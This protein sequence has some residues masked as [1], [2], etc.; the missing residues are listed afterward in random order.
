MRSHSTHEQ[1]KTKLVHDVFGDDD[2]SSN[3]HPVSMDKL[4]MLIWSFREDHELIDFVANFLAKYSSDNY[5]FDGIEFYLPQL[6]HMMIHLRDVEWPDVTLERFAL[7][8]AQKSLHFA[9]QMH[10]ILTGAMQDYQP[11]NSDGLPNERFNA[12]FYRRCVKLRRNLEFAVVFG[13]NHG[14]P[15]YNEM[16]RMLASGEISREEFDVME[17]G[18]YRLNAHRILEGEATYPVSQTIK[19]SKDQAS[20]MDQVLQKIESE[21]CGWL[22]Y[23]R[24]WRKK[25]YKRKGWKHRFF[26]IE[27]GMLYCYDD[28]PRSAQESKVAS[29]MPR[30]RRAMPLEGAKVVLCPIGVYKDENGEHRRNRHLHCFEVIN[31]LYKFKLRAKTEAEALAWVKVLDD[32]SK[33]SSLFSNNTPN[34]S[35][36]SSLNSEQRARYE[37]FKQQ[38]TFVDD[39]CD[40]AEKLRFEEREQRKTLLSDTMDAVTVPDCAYIPM[41]KST[42]TFASVQSLVGNES[43]VFSTNERCPVLMY[44]YNIRNKDNLGITEF[45]HSKYGIKLEAIVESTQD[46]EEDDEQLEEKVDETSTSA[47]QIVNN[48]SDEHPTIET[49]ADNEDGINNVSIVINEPKPSFHKKISSIFRR[50]VGERDNKVSRGF[51]NTNRMIRKLVKDMHLHD[52]PKVIKETLKKGASPRKLTALDK[53]DTLFESVKIVESRSMDSISTNG[54]GTSAME[55]YGIDEA[56]LQNAKVIVCGGETWRERKLRLLSSFQD[57]TEVSLYGD[58]SSVI[59]KSHDD[60]RQEVFVMQMIHYYQSVFVSANLPI[61]LRPYRILSCSKSTGL[62]ETLTD[63]TSIDGLKKS[64]GYPKEGGLRAYFEQVYGAP[65]GKNFKAAQRN[66]MLSLAGYSL[67][68]YLLGLK[69]RHNGNIMIDIHGHLIFIDFGF[70]MGMAPGHEWSLER[71]AF[72][73]TK[74]YVDVM[75]GID[76]ECFKE[77][78]DLFVNG[79]KAARNNSQMALGLVE[80]MMYKSNYPCFSGPRYGGTK[81]LKRF[82]NRLMLNVQEKDIRKKAEKLVMN[83]YNHCGTNLYDKFQLSSNG[84]EP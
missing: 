12:V 51:D 59:A 54:S 72:K 16:Q 62:I 6:A 83:A 8:V 29:D 23:K 39:L 55:D 48:F 37:F 74:E 71:A 31:Q 32:Q 53:A 38:I 20:A 44:F 75:D 21:R 49:T 58:V 36:L 24:R 70:A 45:L 69:D 73:L 64:P 3:N 35:L 81:T 61:W 4:T 57:G 13:A 47:L 33:S 5:I 76:S 34:N 7:I 41:T 67:V 46:E 79:I 56:C 18:E 10:W 25:F 77:F 15:R 14:S 1:F 65:K 40:V 26:V 84:I 50:E 43:R 30:L 60:V 66:F 22:R 2:V 19:D 28:D 42:D 78:K 11:E 68:S 80:I 52:L 9:L 82:E 27:D 17:L 63:S